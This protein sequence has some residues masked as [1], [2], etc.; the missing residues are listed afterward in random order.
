MSK[1]TKQALAVLTNYRY[2][3][4]TLLSGLAL[5]LL[6]ADVVDSVTG[7]AFLGL[8]L[9]SKLLAFVFGYLFYRLAKHWAA[10]G[11]IPELTDFQTL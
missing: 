4:L 11:T 2:Y 10:E 1:S 9:G 8:F 5:L 7:L 6:S 3:V